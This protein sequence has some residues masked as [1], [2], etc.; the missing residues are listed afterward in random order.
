MGQVQSAA[1]KEVFTRS[2]F[3]ASFPICIVFCFNKSCTASEIPKCLMSVVIKSMLKKVKLDKL[4]HCS[5][6]L[7]AILDMIL[8]ALVNNLINIEEAVI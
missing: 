1:K 4:G 2:R 7:V 5:L 6:G 8:R 3:S